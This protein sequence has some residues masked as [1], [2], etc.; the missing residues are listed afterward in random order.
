MRALPAR[1]RSTSRNFIGAL[2]RDEGQS[3]AVRVAEGKYA[4]SESLLRRFVRDV[5]LDQALRPITER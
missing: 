2:Y 4:F 1:R 5:A 3:H